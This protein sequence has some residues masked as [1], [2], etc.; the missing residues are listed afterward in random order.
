M[1][2]AHFGTV[3]ATLSIPPSVPYS[4]QGVAISLK[5]RG[6]SSTY[7]TQLS[8]CR[9]FIDDRRPATVALEAAVAPGGSPYLVPGGTVPLRLATASLSGVPVSNARRTKP[10]FFCA[11]TCSCAWSLIVIS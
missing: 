10:S 1:L 3:D 9:I 7:G 8:S 5:R 11:K 6:G 4:E 2:D